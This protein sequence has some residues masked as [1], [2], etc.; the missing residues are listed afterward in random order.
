MSED[1]DEATGQFTPSS[2]L[3]TDGLYGREYEEALA[4]YTPMATK[5]KEPELT[6]R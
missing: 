2:E 4:G 1:R 6:V 5:E 3:P